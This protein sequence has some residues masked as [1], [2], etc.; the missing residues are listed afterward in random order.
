M[1]DKKMNNLFHHFVIKIIVLHH[2]NQLNISWDNFIANNIFTA[3]QPP[4]A[5]DMPSSSHPIDHHAED[6][7]PPAQPTTSIPPSS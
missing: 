7:H 1:Y 2:L 3:P 5:K 4:H 6:I